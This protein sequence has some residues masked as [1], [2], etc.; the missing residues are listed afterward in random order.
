MLSFA[1]AGAALAAQ[2]SKAV[3]K[4]SMRVAIPGC[5]K[6]RIFTAARRTE[7]EPGSVNVPEGT[8]IRMNGPKKVM[9]EIKAHE[10][11]L[12]QIAGLMKRGQAAPGGIR[13]GG[14]VGISPGPA[15]GPSGQGP[16]AVGGQ[17]F[18]DVEGWR[19]ANGSCP[20]R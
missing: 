19:V 6:G 4:D 2:E 18:I 8:H 12:I 11:S 20:G 13:L 7:E 5:T 17:L 9:E 10:G 15:A 3:P 16:S 14:G 1:L